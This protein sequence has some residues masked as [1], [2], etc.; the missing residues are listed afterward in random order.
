MIRINALTQHAGTDII[1]RY[2][3]LST[4]ADWN[5]RHACPCVRLRVADFTGEASILVPQHLQRIADSLGD[6]DIIDVTLQPCA[7]RDKPGG[8]IGRLSTVDLREIPNIGVLLPAPEC[9]SAA[10]PSLNDLCMV[11]DRISHPALQALLTSTLHAQ[12][13]GFLQSQAGWTYH[14]D[15]PGGLLVHSVTVAQEAE[16]QASAVYP[17]DR[18]RVELITVGGL[19]H[20]LGKAQ[21]IYKGQN[22]PVRSI[23]PH[24]MLT[25]T[26]LSPG[27]DTMSRI[28]PNGAKQ[29]AQMLVWLARPAVVRKPYCDAEIIH[30]ADILDVKADRVRKAFSSNHNP[31][32][33]PA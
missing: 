24:E 32:P 28:W 5:E 4:H 25:I 23:I 15:F 13:R 30:A 2:R 12:Y 20:D 8:T 11:L 19:L 26:A 1:G 3:V 31:V 21:Q 18:H 16:R 22:D 27:L 17:A 6:G 7:L 14:H 33:E 9:P 10:K 29:L